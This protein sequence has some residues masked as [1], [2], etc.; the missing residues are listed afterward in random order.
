MKI[1]ITGAHFTPA[2]AVINELKKMDPQVKIVYAGRKTTMEGDETQSVESKLLPALGVKFIPIIAGRLQRSF[3]IY[4]LP[5]LFKIPIGFIQAVYILLSEKP[6][7]ILSFGGYVALPLVIVGWLGSIPI[8]IHE[9][10]L[11]SG[12]A[13]KISAHFADKIALSFERRTKNEKTIFTGNPLREEILNPVKNLTPDFIKIFN[14]SKKLGL[15]VVLFMGGNQGSHILNKTVE[16]SLDKLLKITCVI[17]ITGDNKYNDFGR[18]GE[19]GRLEKFWERYLVKKWIGEEFGKIVSKVDLVVCRAGIN[20]LTELAYFG[21]NALVIPIPY[22][23]KDEQNENARV[24]QDLGLVRVLPQSKLSSVNL[25]DYIKDMLDNLDDL[26]KKAQG[27][28]KIVIKD[29]AKTLALETL[30]LKDLR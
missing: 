20:T 8:I 15:P 12:L 30:L 4:T 2:V 14:L 13:N 21:K 9:Q 7:V 16:Q 17:H 24:F 28:K 26:K 19:S 1:L 5:S 29:A 3:S 10:T 11:V 27:A 25:L 18:L 22:L 6:D 23:Y